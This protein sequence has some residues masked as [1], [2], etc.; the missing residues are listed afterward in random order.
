MFGVLT[1]TTTMLGDSKL[2]RGI[3]L[4]ALSN[5]VKIATNGAFKS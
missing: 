4:I 2:I 5:V 3:G 1:T